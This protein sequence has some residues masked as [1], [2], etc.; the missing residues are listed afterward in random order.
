MNKKVVNHV[1]QRYWQCVLVVWLYVTLLLAVDF[2][3]LLYTLA[4]KK[5]FWTAYSDPDNGF[6]FFLP[7]HKE[8]VLLTLRILLGRIL[9]LNNRYFGLIILSIVVVDISVLFF[10]FVFFSFSNLH[11]HTPLVNRYTQLNAFLPGGC[12]VG[13]IHDIVPFANNNINLFLPHGL[14]PGW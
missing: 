6:S 9:P 4:G 14:T 8:R 3:I 2:V 7:F 5:W 13:H 11:T 1:W 12:W 10:F